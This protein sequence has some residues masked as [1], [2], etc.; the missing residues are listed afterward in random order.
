M[1]KNS[2]KKKMKTSKQ[3][4]RWSSKRG[5]AEAGIEEKDFNVHKINHVL[6]ID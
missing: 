3:N 4:D 6:L 5:G 2:K 1:T